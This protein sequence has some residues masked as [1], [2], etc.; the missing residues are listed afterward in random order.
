LFFLYN[1]TTVFVV[2][3]RTIVISQ[4]GFRS[5]YEARVFV[6]DPVGHEPPI[7]YETRVLSYLNQQFGN[8]GWHN[9]IRSVASLHITQSLKD[10]EQNQP[11]DGQLYRL[12]KRAARSLKKLDQLKLPNR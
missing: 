12:R 3:T 1:L 5:E 4:S 2:G 11:R 7:S 6:P 8:D 10:A 9:P